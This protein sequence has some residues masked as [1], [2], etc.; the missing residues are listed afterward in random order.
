MTTVHTFSM[1]ERALDLARSCAMEDL[2]H[3]HNISQ[4][5]YDSRE[6]FC[7]KAPAPA[8]EYVR[9]L[10]GATLLLRTNR[11]GRVYAGF[12][13]LSGMRDVLE[14]F[15]RIADVSERVYVFGETDWKPPRHPN[16]RLIPLVRQNALAR[17][18]FLI[19]NSSS[20]RVAVIARDDPG[21]DEAHREERCFRG[22]KTSDP[23]IVKHLAGLAE[24]L[25][26]A[27]LAA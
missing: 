18:S 15:L 13:R 10:I 6:T 21:H 23:A 27:S 9:L 3:V 17:E 11:T 20:L 26:D 1:F 5:D 4:R 2:G 16:M 12:E 14:I 24:G 22:M 7:F 19:A 8:F 25:V